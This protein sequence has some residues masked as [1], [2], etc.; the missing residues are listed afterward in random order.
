MK[1]GVWGA[2]NRKARWGTVALDSLLSEVA[3]LSSA[4]SLF[5]AHAASSYDMLDH[6]TTSTTD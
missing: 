5:Y 1:D 4:A 2:F 3:D 6:V